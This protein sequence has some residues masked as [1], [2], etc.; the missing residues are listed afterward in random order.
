MKRRLIIKLVLLLLT[1][2][3]LGSDISIKQ[4]FEAGTR[5]LAVDAKASADTFIALE[6]QGVKNS[7]L[8]CNLG[9]ALYANND[10][11]GALY[12]YQRAL[13]ISP[14]DK[15]LINN[16]DEALLHLDI[17]ANLSNHL[18]ASRLSNIRLLNN[19]IFVISI[20]L[21]LSAFLYIYR[22]VSNCKRVSVKLLACIAVIFALAF[23]VVFAVLQSKSSSK[24]AVVRG[25]DL[26]TRMGPASNAS[27]AALFHSGEIVEIERIYNRWLKIRLYTGNSAWCRAGQVTVVNDKL[28]L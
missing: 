11:A 16:R 18:Y 6:K 14:C 2:T 22:T 13:L 12:Y 27:K 17:A 24:Y 3:S 28:S 7:A 8:F 9:N 4:K 23:L 19:T 1:R 20:G 21:L 25:G 10:F 5:L 26:T 15:K